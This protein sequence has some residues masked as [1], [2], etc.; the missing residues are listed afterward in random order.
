MLL[1]AALQ[2]RLTELF[3]EAYA[4]HALPQ[5]SNCKSKFGYVSAVEA[6]LQ[7][8]EPREKRRVTRPELS[9]ALILYPANRSFLLGQL[10]RC[11]LP[12]H[13]LQ[14]ALS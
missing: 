7:C 8:F 14:V 2:V 11:N 13:S 10:H 6:N 4:G 1:K 3:T 12:L 9:K 5:C